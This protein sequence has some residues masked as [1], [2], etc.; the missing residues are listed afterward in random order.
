MGSDR[1]AVP[2]KHAMPLYSILCGFCFAPRLRTMSVLL[3]F[4][5]LSGALA[6]VPLSSV[7]RTTS[8][9]LVPNRFI[10]ELDNVSDLPQT[11]RDVRY[12]EA[13]RVY[14]M[15]TI[16]RPFF[17]SM[18]ASTLLLQSVSGGTSASTEN[19]TPPM[20]LLAPPSVFR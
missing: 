13:P 12:H 3:V 18:R 10:V 8:S 1:R 11:K 19:S 16:L 17:R 15:P 14:S 5:L 7:Q 2:L 6:T 9:R 4:A 20:S